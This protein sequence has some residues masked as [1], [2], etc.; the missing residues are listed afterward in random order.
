[1]TS[2][3]FV[4]GIFPPDPGGPATYVP[5]VAT[6]LSSRMNVLGVI[7]TSAVERTDEEY[8]FRVVR[9]PR[10]NRFL[11]FLRVVS[12]IRR[13]AKD[14]DVVYANGLVFETILTC[15]VLGRKRVAVKV[16]GDLIW[17][18]AQLAGETALTIDEFQ[19]ARHGPIPRLLRALQS[20]Y[21]RRADVVITPSEYLARIVEGWGVPRER[22]RV[23]YNAAEA[24][25]AEAASPNPTFDVVTVCRL[26]PWKG[27]EALI[28]IAKK[29]GWS[30][31]I[32]GDG[33]QRDALAALA[34]GDEKIRFAGRVPAERVR[35]EIRSARVFVLNSTYEGLPHVVLEAQAARV[36]VVATDAGGTGEAVLDGR[37]GLLVPVGDDVALEEAL[38]SI[39]ESR[40]KGSELVMAA[41]EELR[42]RFAY[43]AMI[44][45]TE[46]IL[47]TLGT[48]C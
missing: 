32:V 10:A 25:I 20:W 39:L 6:A 27:V 8:P 18:R 4:T 22:V 36:P 5:R 17:E 12:T 21:T 33:M 31:N 28:R 38:A 16:V 24:R 35:D 2:V 29:R 14:A 37:T 13:L 41:V 26:V 45:Y 44:E 48:S 34:G 3:L 42:G 40:S 47:S 15:K 43:D 30:L 46:G 1:V 11:R 19:T 9:I 7:T 23:V